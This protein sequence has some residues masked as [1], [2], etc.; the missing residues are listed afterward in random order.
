MF[1]Q[2]WNDFHALLKTV[3]DKPK[4]STANNPMT[5]SD[6]D[7]MTD[8]RILGR[9]S[10]KSTSSKSS[11]H[12]GKS[13][14]T[15]GKGKG[16]S[17]SSSIGKDFELPAFS[18]AGSSVKSFVYKGGENDDLFG[19]SS[20]SLH[21]SS[22]SSLGLN[23][24]SLKAQSPV[25]PAQPQQ[26]PA[27]P[28]A[29][30]VNSRPY[31]DPDSNFE[32]YITLGTSHL[33]NIQN[34]PQV[35]FFIQSAKGYVKEALAFLNGAKKVERQKSLR[36]SLRNVRVILL[37][38]VYQTISQVQQALNEVAGG[39]QGAA[40]LFPG[41]AASLR[42]PSKQQFKPTSHAASQVPAQQVPAAGSAANQYY[43]DTASLQGHIRAGNIHL[44]NLRQ[45]PGPISIQAASEYVK[46]VNAYI[47]GA[48]IRDQEQNNLKAALTQVIHF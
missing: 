2:L 3:G 33:S 43:A 46:S 23:I 8:G 20:S 30:Q 11:K 25:I 29:L 28:A 9:R 35:P 5:K 21:S 18:S 44:N 10:S 39:G 12:S 1:F 36:A 31:E 19:K 34:H 41:H 27:V 14:K 16:S 24:P 26:Q 22:G 13:S 48:R 6:F 45:Y 7:K 42:I 37:R 17:K 38:V 4:F 47:G 32:T 40:A 15:S